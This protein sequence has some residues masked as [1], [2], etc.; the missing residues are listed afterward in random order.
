M[1]QKDYLLFMGSAYALLVIGG[2]VLFAFQASQIDTFGLLFGV[3][4]LAFFAYKSY[5]CF[6]DLK[7]VRQED[8]VFAPPTDA[9]AEEQIS[10]FKRTLM[11][12][13]I[14]FPILS[15]WIWFDLNSLESNEVE[16]VRIWEPVAFLYNIG[17]YWLAVLS[18]PVLSLFVMGSLFKKV[19]DLKR[20]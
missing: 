14:V 2:L 12:S 9:T 10:Y 5:T 4:L 17:G 19:A 16:S 11:L 20:E 7:T 3:C 18:T 6:R 15:I 8:M 13:A 1:K